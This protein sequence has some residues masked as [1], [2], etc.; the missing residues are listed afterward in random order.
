LIEELSEAQATG[1]VLNQR[2]AFEH[3]NRILGEMEIE[4]K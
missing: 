2:Q 3:I 1:K 4:Q